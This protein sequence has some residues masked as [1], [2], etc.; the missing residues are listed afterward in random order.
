MWKYFSVHRPVGIGTYP[1][2][3]MKEFE[4]FDYRKEVRD[5]ICAWGILYYDRKLTEK[6]MHD[7]E[8]LPD[9]EKNRTASYGE[10]YYIQ[11]LPDKELMKFYQALVDTDYRTE[12]EEDYMLAA[13]FE[14]EE[15]G[16]EC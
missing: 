10:I 2:E 1:K 15:R 9:E 3:G 7:Y 5:G 11:N 12:L 4:N 8:L 16:L 14:M 6:E 13:E